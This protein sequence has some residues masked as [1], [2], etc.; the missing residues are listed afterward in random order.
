M[1]TDTDVVTEW[2]GSAPTQTREILKEIRALIRRAAPEATEDIRYGIPTFLL[3]GNLVHYAGYEGHIG[4]YPGPEALEKFREELSSWTGGK[5]SVRFPLDRPV[6]LDLI[7]EIT[8][9]RV[10]QQRMKG[11][12]RNKTQKNSTEDIAETKQED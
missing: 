2:I 8:A 7:R 12:I 3:N 10:Q 6:P 11:N 5:G 4:F 9:W 1:D